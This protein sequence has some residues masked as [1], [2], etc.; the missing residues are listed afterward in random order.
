MAHLANIPHPK[1]THQWWSAHDVGLIKTTENKG[2]RK[3]FPLENVS[4]AVVGT[5]ILY[6]CGI[7]EFEP[8]QRIRSS[9]INAFFRIGSVLFFVGKSHTENTF[10]SCTSFAPND[11]GGPVV[12]PETGKVIAIATQSTAA[13]SNKYGLPALSGATFLLGK[14]TQDFIRR[15]MGRPIK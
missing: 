10:G 2:F 4:Q 1:F 8:K 15:Q 6:G 13:T 3:N 9:G 14:S 5:S 12:N 11:S 7:T